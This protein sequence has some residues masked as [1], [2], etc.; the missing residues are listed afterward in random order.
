MSNIPK[1]SFYFLRHGE[2]DWNKNH[3][4]MGQKDIPLNQTG[5]QQAYRA[6]ELLKNC[7]FSAIAVSPLKRAKQTAEIIAE[8]FSVPMIEIE[9]LKECS[10]GIMEGQL[11][12]YN[13]WV[14]A[15][16]NGSIISGAETYSSFTKRAILGIQKALKHHSEPVLIIAH[17]GIYEVIQRG[18]NS[19][20]D[21]LQNCVPI[22]HRAPSSTNNLWFV[23]SLDEEE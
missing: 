2:T 9:E 6:A 11:K 10:L 20:F 16:H 1:K 7:S 17:G 21:N 13:H 8:K 5:I 4:A 22:Y 23:Y 19:P 18:V 3:I 12:G 14:G 15:W